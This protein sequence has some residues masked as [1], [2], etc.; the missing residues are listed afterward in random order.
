ME[1]L[2]SGVKIPEPRGPTGIEGHIAPMRDLFAIEVPKPGAAVRAMAAAMTRLQLPIEPDPLKPLPIFPDQRALP[3]HEI[4]QKNIMPPRVTV[5]E[6]DRDLARGNVRP[7]GRYRPDVGEGS[8]IAEFAIAGINHEQVQIFISVLIVEQHDVA[9]VRAPILPVDRPAPGARDRHAG[10]SA[11]DR[12][13]PDGQHPVDR[14]KP[15]DQTTV[16]RQSRA[17]EC[18][19]VEQLSARDQGTNRH[20]G[21]LSYLCMAARLTTDAFGI[22]SPE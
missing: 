20:S 16:R 17:E 7:I 1:V 13:D 22:S 5:V 3:G 11:V 21:P 12:R 15:R 14:D 10:G 4:K 6:V 9:T 18:R 2:A 19:I 8:E